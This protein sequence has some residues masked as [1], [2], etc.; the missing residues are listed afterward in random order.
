MSHISIESVIFMLTIGVVWAMFLHI[1]LSSDM[2]KALELI[3][4]HM[5]VMSE[6]HEG[7]DM[8][9]RQNEDAL[10]ECAATMSEMVNDIRHINS[11][12]DKLVVEH[13]L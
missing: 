7:H 1:R 3:G 13:D 11:K 4:K 2:M 9:F 6:L 8:R 10:K 12:L 5:Q